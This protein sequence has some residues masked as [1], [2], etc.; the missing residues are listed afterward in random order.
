MKKISIYN[1]KGGV[2]KTTVSCMLAGFLAYVKGFKVC[3]L[4]F[5]APTYHFSELRRVEEKILSDPKSPLSVWLREHPSK[6]TPYTIYRIPTD[7]AGVYRPEEVF[8]IM[9]DITRQDFDYIIIDFPGRF[10]A[11]EPVSFMAASG[12]IDFV[13]VPTDTDSQARKSALVISEA[14][15]RAGVPCTVFWNK[16]TVYEA[17]GDGSRF[18]RGAEPF[19]RYGVPVMDEVVREIRKFSRD[20]DEHLF[21]RSTMCFPDR[22][23]RQWIP[24]LIPFLEALTDRIDSSKRNRKQ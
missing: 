17:R 5:D 11:D 6:V 3:V 19:L 8:A 18:R 10:S 22:Y 24:S 15:T 14:L 21:I 12:L 4:D 2:G 1:E 20:A 7:G 13:A 9:R 23:I 16:V